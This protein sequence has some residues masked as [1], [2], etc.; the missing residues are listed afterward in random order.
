M[1]QDVIRLIHALRLPLGDEAAYQAGLGRALE[2]AGIGHVREHR[3]GPGDRVD[4][5]LDDGTAVEVKLRGQARRIYAQCERY[6]GYPEVR[7]LLLAT[8]RAMGLPPEIAGKP[9][10][11]ASLGRGWL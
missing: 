9:V 8:N 3:L 4:F 5:M 7:G 6:C 1:V 2:G 11:Y 10:W